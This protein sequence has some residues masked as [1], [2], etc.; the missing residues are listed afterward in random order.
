[1]IRTIQFLPW[2]L[3]ILLTMVLTVCGLTA[4]AQVYGPPLSMLEKGEM[5]VGVALGDFNRKIRVSGNTSSGD[6]SRETLFVDW[7]FQENGALRFELSSVDLGNLRGQEFAA[8]YRGRFG[9]TG[10]VGDYDLMKGFL[11]G[12]RTGDFSEAGVE[13]DLIQI[14]VAAGGM[15]HISDIFSVYFAGLF[16]KLDGTINSIEFEGDSSVGIYG[17]VLFKLDESLHFGAELHTFVQSG[18]G[19][20]TQFKF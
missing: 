5:A 12:V 15:L 13:A 2:R 14:D 10:K 6:Y 8:S 16:S 4:Q 7:G 9:A 11:A 19:L 18:F 20:Y 17:G 1:M 3:A